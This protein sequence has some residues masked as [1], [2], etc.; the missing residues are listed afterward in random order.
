MPLNMAAT[1]L[2]PIRPTL[3][4]KPSLLRQEISR[5]RPLLFPIHAKGGKRFRELLNQ[6]KDKEKEPEPSAVSVSSG[7]GFGEKRVSKK[8][9]QAQASSNHSTDDGT[10]EITCSCGGGENKL[11]YVDCCMPYHKGNASP[12]DGARYSA[13]A[14]GIVGYIVSTTHPENP[15]Y[16]DDLLANAQATCDRL[17]FYKLEI[18]QYEPISDQESTVTFRAIYGQKKKGQADRK[19]MEEKSYFVREGDVWLFKNGETLKTASEVD[20]PSSMPPITM[21]S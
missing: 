17:K 4:G 2:L 18:L 13:Y 5:V 20:L 16:G 19:M 21:N 8:D 6:R 12:P 9:G 14:H 15:D 11:R 3:S 1:S 7:R 10:G